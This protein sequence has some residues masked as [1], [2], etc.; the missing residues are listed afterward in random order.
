MNVNSL[1]NIYV[2]QMKKTVIMNVR[3]LIY[4]ILLGAGM[5]LQAQDLFDK[6]EDL[7]SQVVDEN[8]L[9]DYPSLAEDN[10]DLLTL[11][12]L[13]ADYSWEEQ[14]EDQQKA[15]LVNAYNILVIKQITLNWPMQSPLEDPLFFN[16]RKHLVGGKEM[17][18]DEIEKKTLF[19]KFDDPRLHF[20]LVC[21]AMDCPPL[22]NK[23]YRSETLEKQLEDQTRYALNLESFILTDGKKLQ[24][25]EIFKWYRDDFGSKP[26]KVI[27]FINGYRKEKLIVRNFGYYPYNWL[28]NVQ[29]K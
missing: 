5:T 3:N 1:T 27:D 25:S 29:T 24:L 22:L 15:F 8:G 16:G 19:K 14:N 23:A 20:V 2:R 13:I 11:A 21:G 26:G 6:T 28:V 18:L 9:V 4:F 12:S 10:A 17:T 7:L